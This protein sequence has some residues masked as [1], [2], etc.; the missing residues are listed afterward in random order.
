MQPTRRWFW[1]D[2][3]DMRMSLIAATRAFVDAGL[4]YDSSIY[5]APNDTIN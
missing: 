1:S 5:R 2:I 4:N 3:H